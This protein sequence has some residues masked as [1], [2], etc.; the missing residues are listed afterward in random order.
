MTSEAGAQLWQIVLQGDWFALGVLGLL[1][2]MSALSW[3][4]IVL[5][6]LQ[7]GWI[8]LANRRFL[9]RFRQE[10]QLSRLLRWQ[11]SARGAPLAHMF[12]ASVQELQAFGGQ[13]TRAGALDNVDRSMEL[14]FNRQLIDLERW[15]PSL[16]TTSS[17]APFVGLFGTVLGIIDA[18]GS[19]GSV[20]VTSLAVVAP[21]ISQAL[22]AT[23]AGL[24]VA[25][26][27]LVAYNLFRQRLRKIS[28]QMQNFALE[29]RNRYQRPH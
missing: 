27:A 4:V 5:K 14:Q 22:V 23:A 9:R 29:L 7:F 19:I 10:P 20:G 12:R 13:P 11:V 25:V 17:T 1:V 18:F 6:G 26:P 15:L 28:G 3:A 16:A 21:G 24:A 2:L 8:A